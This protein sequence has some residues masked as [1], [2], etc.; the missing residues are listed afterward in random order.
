MGARINESSLYFFRII[1]VEFNYL[2]SVT[3]SLSNAQ[4]K[5]FSFT[6]D[7]MVIAIIEI[8][9]LWFIYHI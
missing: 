6:V 2:K 9:A 7:V 3:N 4:E 8:L 1:D 5:T